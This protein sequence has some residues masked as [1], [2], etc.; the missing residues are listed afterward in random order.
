MRC[1]VDYCIYNR[2]CTC[3]CQTIKV[4]SFGMCEECTFV[5]FKKELLDAEKE[6]QLQNSGKR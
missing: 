6:R 2:D 3:I 5:S 4:N 1:E